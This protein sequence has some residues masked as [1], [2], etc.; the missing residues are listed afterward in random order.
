MAL[1]PEH[2]CMGGRE[3]LNLC[4]RC[5]LCQYRGVPICA[6]VY[7]NDRGDKAAIVKGL[8]RDIF[9]DGDGCAQEEVTDMFQNQPQAAD[10]LPAKGCFINNR[11]EPVA[12][13]RTIPVVAPAEGVV[14]AEIAASG[15]GEVDRAVSAARAAFETG[16]WAALTA[17]ERGR[18]IS[19]L[20]QLILDNYD[21]LVAL[22]AR[23]CGKPMATA[24]ADITATARYFEYYGGAADKVHGEQIP[25]LNGYYATGEREP[26]GVTGHVI[27]WNYPAQM[28]GRTLGAALAMGNATVLKP[29]EDACLS[30]LRIA[31]L[32]VEAGFPEGAINVV[33]GLGHEA[34]AALSEHTGLDFISFTGSPQVG[35]MI[36]TAAARNHIGCVLE[37][38]G[39]SPQIVFDD[40]DFEAAVPMIV[41]A[42]IQNAGQ[43]CSAGARLLV[44]RSAWDRLIP[45][46]TE[47]FA[48]LRAGMPEDAPDLG[49][50][51][52]ARQ[53]ER[54][55]AFIAAA[56]A[57]G[58][59]VLAEGG[60]QDGA[61]EAGFYVPP[62]LFGPVPRENALARDE[63]FGPVLSAMPFEDEA[64]ALAL[65][66]GTDYG[67]IA[68]VWTGD[69]ARA[70]RLA[71]KLRVGQ[72]YVNAYGAG[73]GVELPFGGVRKSGH[74]REK[75][76]EALYEFSALKTIVIKHD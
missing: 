12:S 30:V 38:G 66:N 18:L 55:E 22:E 27:P 45:M 13:G 28:A 40:A 14:F 31:E 8:N 65:A 21:E 51:I 73:G 6:G 11:W 63:V 49:P 42:I 15:A 59:P 26:L 60:V 10:I 37:L 39:K 36:Q 64:D 48:E 44:Q 52:S 62:V 35:T 29:A 61:P 17:T 58:V 75:G 25:F 56:K 3:F 68:G 16:A 53:K 46:V 5:F 47:R 32:S 72:V 74:G 20:G 69:S 71:R 70:V 54:V 57:E 67:L 34:G 4:W 43:T 9:R 2:F 24:R 1:Y 41:A 7:R 76:F 50:I 23:D 33:P 19:R